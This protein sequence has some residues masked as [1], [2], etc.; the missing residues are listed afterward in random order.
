[1]ALKIYNWNGST[2]QFTEGQQP[3]GA[4]LAGA[5]PPAAPTVK[6]DPPKNKARTPRNKTTKPAAPEPQATDVED[7][8]D[9]DASE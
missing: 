6:A 4:T 5:T 2:Y 1:M 3:A 9:P 7:A 8:T